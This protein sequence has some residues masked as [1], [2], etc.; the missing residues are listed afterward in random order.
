MVGRPDAFF[1]VGHEA[2]KDGRLVNVR[3][4]FVARRVSLPFPF[5]VGGRVPFAGK[6]PRA[7]HRFVSG[8]AGRVNRASGKAGN[9]GDLFAPFH[10]LQHVDRFGT[11]R[12]VFRHGVL[13][14]FRAGV[15]AA[16]ADVVVADF[17][18]PFAVL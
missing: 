5:A 8:F 13:K 6:A 15:V 1:G 14:T 17:A 12:R 2:E 7:V 16:E 4:D 11:G 3:V 10:G 18:D 9:A